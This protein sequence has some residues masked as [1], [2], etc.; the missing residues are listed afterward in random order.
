MPSPAA[1]IGA[2]LGSALAVASAMGFAI[3]L[4][5]PPPG[6][7]PAHPLTAAPIRPSILGEAL[8]TGPGLT[9]S[10]LGLAE[11]CAAFWSDVLHA[12]LR[13]M[14]AEARIENG[15]PELV[16]ATPRRFVLWTQE[17]TANHSCA[18]GNADSPM[19]P[20]ASALR[21]F[22]IACR[23]AAERLPFEEG[24]SRDAESCVEEFI[25][26]RLSAAEAVARRRTGTLPFAAET[27]LAFYE[28][29][30]SDHPNAERLASL[31]AQLAVA[32]PDAADVARLAAL[33]AYVRFAKD[34]SS[35]LARASAQAHLRQDRK[36][37]V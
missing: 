25:A 5:L 6:G 17:L 18:T 29:L 19:A 24:V 37:V 30:R 12:D 32:A 10:G 23:G 26:M 34:S 33:M 22:L 11:D 27:H 20:A 31:T 4:C 36:S 21:D 16:F 13:P 14:G 8:L 3:A 9:L 2:Y 15:R 35:A 28:L 1:R 7:G